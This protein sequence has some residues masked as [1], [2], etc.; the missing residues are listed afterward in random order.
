[1]CERGYCM[2][3]SREISVMDDGCRYLKTPNVTETTTG[4]VPKEKQKGAK[5]ESE[6]CDASNQHSAFHDGPIHIHF[7]ARATLPPPFRAEPPHDPT[8]QLQTKPLPVLGAL[9]PRTNVTPVALQTR[10]S[11]PERRP[12]IERASS[13]HG[14]GTIANAT[15]GPQGPVNLTCISQENS[16]PH[17]EVDFGLNS[18]LLAIY[19]NSQLRH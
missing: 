15:S 6:S 5:Q 16:G 2:G 14:L 17:H 7:R 9:A 1:M 13:L 11:L 3:V 19:L 8:R 18:V 10:G 4:R 12:N